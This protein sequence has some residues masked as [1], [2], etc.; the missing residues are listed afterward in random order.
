MGNE[1]REEERV[2]QEEESWL[3]LRDRAG[4]GKRSILILTGAAHSILPGPS[5][6]N[7]VLVAFE[8]LR[9]TIQQDFFMELWPFLHYNCTT[10]VIVE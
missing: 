5:Q 1:E 10:L 2:E 3:C 9:R 6:H 4:L 7:P 8:P